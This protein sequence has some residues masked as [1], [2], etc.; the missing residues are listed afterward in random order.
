MHVQ[1]QGSY[2]PLHLAALNGHASIV[3]ALVA[4][5]ADLEAKDEVCDALIVQGW[6]RDWN[7]FSAV[8]RISYFDY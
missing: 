7:L 6:V 1:L 4:A 8:S 3:T 5:G 2:C